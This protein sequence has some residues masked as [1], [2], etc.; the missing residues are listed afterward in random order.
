MEG[1]SSFMCS[2]SL[3]FFF[4]LVPMTKLHVHS[5]LFIIVLQNV[6]LLTVRIVPGVGHVRDVILVL[7]CIRELS[8]LSV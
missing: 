5:L 8:G 7:P 4:V 6:A 3:F 1:I 2:K